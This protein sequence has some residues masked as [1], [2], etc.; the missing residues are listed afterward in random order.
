M[1]SIRTVCLFDNETNLKLAARNIELN[2]V[3]DKANKSFDRHRI[4]LFIQ[5]DRKIFEYEFELFYSW[6]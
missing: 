3:G 4:N 2:K 5:V 1:F 6:L